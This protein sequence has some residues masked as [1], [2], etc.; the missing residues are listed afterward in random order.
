MTKRPPASV[1]PSLLP[2]CFTPDPRPTAYTMLGSFQETEG[3]AWPRPTRFAALW[4]WNQMVKESPARQKGLTLLG[5]LEDDLPEDQKR[6]VLDACTWQFIPE[7]EA[8]ML[9]LTDSRDSSY[10][11]SSLAARALLVNQG[12]KHYEHLVEK[13]QQ[14][15]VAG[16]H[17]FSMNASP[18]C[19]R[20]IGGD[21]LK[22][23]H[24]S[25]RRRSWSGRGAS[26]RTVPR[27]GALASWPRNWES[28]T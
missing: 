13:A 24:R 23:G 14:S 9:R 6:M 20:G 3:A 2:I 12:H 16:K 11:E 4:A 19:T 18:G 10:W 15:T 1:L 22:S 7:T 26:L 21:P 28:V 25:W 8:A 27:I 5:L 17:G